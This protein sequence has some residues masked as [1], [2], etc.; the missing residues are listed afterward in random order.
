MTGAKGVA[1]D[2]DTPAPLCFGK[3]L[4]SYFSIKN[5]QSLSLYLP[6]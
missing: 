3:S 2:S 1:L 4:L 6:A 5:R